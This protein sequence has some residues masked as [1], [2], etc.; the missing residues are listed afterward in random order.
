MPE[1]L[2][3][4]KTSPTGQPGTELK[5]IVAVGH[6]RVAKIL[7]ITEMLITS[8]PPGSFVS[9]V[10]QVTPPKGGRGE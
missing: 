1:L 6:V 8:S 4:G 2:L 10:V 7:E 3:E 5:N 9:I